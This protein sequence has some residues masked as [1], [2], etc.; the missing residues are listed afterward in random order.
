MFDLS[1]GNPGAF[2]DTYFATELALIPAWL[3]ALFTVRYQRSFRSRRGIA[4]AAA[5]AGG[6]LLP[7]VWNYVY[8]PGGIEGVMHLIF[9]FP[10]ALANGVLSCAWSSVTST[11]AR[12][13]RWPA[14]RPFVVTAALGVAGWANFLLQ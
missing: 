8:R 1:P 10:L 4:L 6:L 13:P 14:M 7:G 12:E 11:D 3:V 5:I 9:G 2:D